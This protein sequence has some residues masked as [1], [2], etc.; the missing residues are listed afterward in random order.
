MENDWIDEIEQ[1][2]IIEPTTNESSAKIKSARDLL[3]KKRNPRKNTN[4]ISY[5]TGY[6]DGYKACELENKNIWYKQGYD[7]ALRSGA[8]LD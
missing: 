7:N 1:Q 4:N 8:L 3:T 6:H 2:D 5:Q